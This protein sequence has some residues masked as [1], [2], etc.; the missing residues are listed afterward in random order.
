M[1]SA[2]S[3]HREPGEFDQLVTLARQ[4][5]A[6]IRANPSQQPPSSS[7]AHAAFDPY[8]ARKLHTF[9]PV[10]VITVPNPAQTLDAYD[11]LLDGCEELAR[12][13]KTYHIT[14][15]DVSHC[16]ITTSRTC[17]NHSSALQLLGCYRSWSSSLAAQPAY[18]RSCTQVKPT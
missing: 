11:G 6:I 17:A 2:N 4:L 18:I 15:W 16:L 7:P 3:L 14:T 13:S 1:N 10:R 8:I 12:L 9:L 5:L